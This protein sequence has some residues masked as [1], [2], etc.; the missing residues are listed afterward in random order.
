MISDELEDFLELYGS[1][2]ARDEA[3]R[4]EKLGAS[5]FNIRTFQ[6]NNHGLSKQITLQVEIEGDHQ[7]RVKISNFATVGDLK[8]HIANKLN[9]LHEVTLYYGELELNDDSFILYD[10]GIKNG[11]KLQVQK[12]AWLLPE[13]LEWNDE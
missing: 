1:K 8:T 2:A 9:I 13:P 5:H 11:A 12:N 3:R 6:R 10:L 7:I 4:L